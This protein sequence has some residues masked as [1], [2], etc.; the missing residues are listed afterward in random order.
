MEHVLVLRH[1]REHR[2]LHAAVRNAVGRAAH[3]ERAPARPVDPR[4]HAAADRGVPHGAG[5]LRLTAFGSVRR[6]VLGGPLELVRAPL[7]VPLLEIGRRRGQKGRI[8]DVVVLP[9]PGDPSDRAGH[10]VPRRRDVVQPC[11][12]RLR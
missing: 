4:A 10:A 3:D 11:G 12:K 5:R 7:S 2:R 1:L 9:R 6:D 8:R